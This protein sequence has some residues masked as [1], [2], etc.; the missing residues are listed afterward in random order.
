MACHRSLE[1]PLVIALS[2]PGPP[3]AVLNAGRRGFEPHGAVIES[4]IAVLLAP[5]PEPPLEI[6]SLS[7]DSS[8]SSSAHFVF[9]VYGHAYKLQSEEPSP[10]ENTGIICPCWQQ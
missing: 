6:K 7:E 3:S 5:L 9:T 1:I 2:I 4:D 8:L 10:K